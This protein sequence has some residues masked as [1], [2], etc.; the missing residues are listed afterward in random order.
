MRTFVAY[1]AF[2][3]FWIAANTRSQRALVRVPQ[4]REGGAASIVGDQ[5]VLDV[6]EVVDEV[7]ARLV[8]R[9]LTFLERVP[10]IDQNR[11][12]VLLDSP[13]LRQA[14]TIY[15]FASPVA[16]WLIW[17]VVGMYA[18]ALL[19]RHPHGPA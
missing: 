16:Q 2:R 19:S 4:G 15:A 12:I 14:Q 13:A 6:S 9:G 5:V 3:H 1:D 10:T 8:E 7:K 18:G 17:V 11:Q